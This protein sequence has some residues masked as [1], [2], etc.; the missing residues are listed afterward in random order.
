[1]QSARILGSSPQRTG[2]M[3]VSGLNPKR[4]ILW[5]KRIHNQWLLEI[6][7]STLEENLYP[8]SVLYLSKEE[9]DQLTEMPDA[10]EAVE[11]AFVQLS[12]GKATNVPRNYARA[13]GSKSVCATGET[14]VLF[15]PVGLAIED[16]ALAAGRTS[17]GSAAE[18]DE[19][20]DPPRVD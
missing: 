18:W 8:V 5:G 6:C 3:Q 10:L 16:L 2:V 7:R 17:S 9:V 19:T 13:P 20:P 1:M 14:T 12:A 4:R 15:K 11:R